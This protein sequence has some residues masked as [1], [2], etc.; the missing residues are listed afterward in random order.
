MSTVQHTTVVGIFDKLRLA[1]QAIEELRDA[2][3]MEKEIGMVARN[4]RVTQ[5][6]IE[7]SRHD[8]RVAD[9]ALGGMVT[10]AGLG[11]LWAVAVE[12]EL[13]PAI[14]E[15]VLGGIFSGLLAGAIA[16]AAGG[17]LIGAL[18]A[19]GLTRRQAETYEE[20]LRAGRVIVTVHT[21]DRYDEALRILRSNGAELHSGERLV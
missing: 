21:E 10:G 1:Q 12:I 20:E 15:L 13:L 9:G 6:P 5:V 2:G 18:L 11:G 8:E 17:G 7:Q 16:G 3:F 19:I 4:V 14:G